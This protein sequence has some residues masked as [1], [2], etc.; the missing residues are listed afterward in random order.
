MRKI[1]M[2][3]VLASLSLMAQA[4]GRYVIDGTVSTAPEG[5]VVKLFRN[6]G[7]ILRPVASDT[8][9]DNLF[10]FEGETTGD[11]VEPMILFAMY[12]GMASMVLDVYVR[13]AAV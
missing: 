9:T 8:I 4:Q 13:P 10:H 5:A 6:T 11:G 3:L 2:S 12:N 1:L 7:N